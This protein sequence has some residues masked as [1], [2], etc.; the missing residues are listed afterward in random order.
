M[1]CIYLKYLYI[2]VLN[3]SFYCQVMKI[4]NNYMKWIRWITG[5]MLLSAL[6]Y[7]RPVFHQQNN[8][9]RKPTEMGNGSTRSIMSPE[10]SGDERINYGAEEEQK[11]DSDLINK[12]ILINI[13]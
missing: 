12:N 1:Y 6:L 2:F 7:S 11:T 9:D 10:I 5:I 13:L 3:L 4:N 8:P